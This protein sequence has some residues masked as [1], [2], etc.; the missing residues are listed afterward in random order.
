M[1]GWGRQV[2]LF[3][4][5]IFGAAIVFLTCQNSLFGFG[6]RVHRAKIV[7]SLSFELHWDI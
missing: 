5:F 6:C 7:S 4:P 1:H 3:L 2:I